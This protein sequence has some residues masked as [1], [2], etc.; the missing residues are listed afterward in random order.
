MK[1]F[2][3]LF[4]VGAAVFLFTTVAFADTAVHQAGQAEGN[5]AALGALAQ[6]K[7]NAV[8]AK[9]Q[10]EGAQKKELGAVQNAKNL[11]DEADLKEGEGEDL[12]AIDDGDTAAD[13]AAETL[14]QEK[15]E[16][17]TK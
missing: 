14:G 16:P 5:K 6:G 11:G 17:K 10:V 4:V 12:N 2:S 8:D 7:K 3:R 15:A 9:A 13:E 1:H